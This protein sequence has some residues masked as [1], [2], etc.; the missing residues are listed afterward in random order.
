[1]RTLIEDLLSYSRAGR[2]VTM[3]PVDCAEVVE[4]V[5]R[6]LGP[7]LEETGGSVT[8][9]GDLPTVLVDRS[10]LTQVFANLTA[11]ALKYR[12]PEVAPAVHVSAR[13]EEGAWL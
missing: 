6:N 2:E 12:R 1:M 3:T 7:A 8:V 4:E 13:R 5:R 10:Q 11:N 9:H